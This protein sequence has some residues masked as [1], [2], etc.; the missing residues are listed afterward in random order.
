MSTLPNQS[1]IGEPSPGWRQRVDELAK[2]APLLSPPAPW[3]AFE[4]VGL[5]L[6][7]LIVMSYILWDRQVIQWSLTLDPSQLEWAQFLSHAAHGKVI[8]PA[9]VV[10][11]VVSLWLK[12]AV[13]QRWTTVWILGFAF[14]SIAVNLLKIFFGRYRPKTLGQGFYGFEPFSVGYEM[15]SFPSGHSAAIGA[16]L[17]VVLLR[18]PRLWPVWIVAALGWGSCRVFSHAHYIGDVLAGLYLGAGCTFLAYAILRRK[19][20]WNRQ[21]ESGGVG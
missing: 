5:A 4:L 14:E 8:I 6:V 18:G 13:L 21:F 2:P 16:M 1:D 9:M 12:R 3:L 11:L 17:G 20:W 7:P 19:A 15:N 10:L